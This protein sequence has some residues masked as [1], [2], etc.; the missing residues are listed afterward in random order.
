MTI[1]DLF[2]KSKVA[3]YE[4]AE[5]ASADIESAD[6]LKK[7]VEDNNTFI[8][9]TDFSDPS[10]FIKFG[11]AELYY[12]NSIKRVYQ[13][14]PYDG[15][16]KEKLEFQLS[17]SYLDRWLYDNKYPKSTGY[18]ILT[19]GGYGASTIT[20]G[21]GLSSDHEYIYAAGGLHTASEGMKS[22]ELFK[23]FDSSIK[24]DVRQE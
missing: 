14:Y 16:A 20:D 6:F 8:P 24:Y 12:E 22:G 10:R 5:S 18:A 2:S 13:Q 4:S 15:S 21:Y 1:K 9:F 7:K 17:S 11:S 19:A 3:V 23:N